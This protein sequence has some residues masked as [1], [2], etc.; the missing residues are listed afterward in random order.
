MTTT[1]QDKE[2]MAEEGYSNRELEPLPMDPYSAGDVDLDEELTLRSKTP[3]DLDSRRVRHYFSDSSNSFFCPMSPKTQ[4]KIGVGLMGLALAVGLT[5]VT[6]ISL[7]VVTLGLALPITILAIVLAGAI[8]SAPAVL[9]KD[10]II[11]F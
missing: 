6:L 11:M 3:V 5:W 7:N 1:K 8:V 2:L 4:A 10:P 9:Q